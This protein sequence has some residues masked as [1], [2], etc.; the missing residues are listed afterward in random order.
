MLV[1]LKVQNYALI[2]DLYVEF[3]PGLNIITG[4]TGAG[5]S[6]LLGA[7]SL[8]LGKRVETSVLKNNDQ[9]CVVEAEFKIEIDNLKQ[10]FIE[11]DI[12]FDTHVVFRREILNTGKS[13]A[14][15]NDTPVNLNVL[16]E[17]AL[18]LVDIHSQH[19]NLLL[20]Q[21]SYIMEFVDAYAKNENLL[22]EYQTIYNLY[23]TKEKDY[24][25]KLI[26]F[27]RIKDE[28]DL[29]SFQCNQLSEAKLVPG[30]ISELEIEIKQLENAGEIKS[31]LHDSEN[32]LNADESGIIDLLNAASG[33]LDKIKDVFPQASVMSERLI[34]ALIELKDVESE[35]AK[36]FEKLEFNPDRHLQISERLDLLN[37]LLQKFRK[38]EILELIELRDELQKKIS[39][40]VDGEF[41]LLQQKKE[42]DGLLSTLEKKAEELTRKRIDKFP[43][44]ESEISR[45]LIEM[46]MN[47]A[48]VEFKHLL[49]QLSP[50][51][52]DDIGLF[53]TANKN[54]PLQE[55][56]RI[57]SGGELSRLMLAVK[58]L[59]SGS[60]KMPTLILDEIDTGVSGEIA[61]K[62]GNIIKQMSKNSQIINITHLPQV[63]SKGEAHYLVYKDHNHTL[64]RTMIRK[65]NESERV[66][67]IAKMLS[68]EQLSEAAVEN[69]RVLL[70]K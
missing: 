18:Q 24:Q 39:V 10:R 40:V 58:A 9:K 43:A 5:K 67:E 21:Q 56:S 61:D 23:R 36:S 64:T 51:G 8:I 70:G 22:S 29:L 55:V 41:E 28:M 49:Q 45:M 15:I 26:E 52:A 11:N 44:L 20:N 48:R 27:Q 16:Q 31:A 33:R 14:F 65:L 1:S 69:A 19:Q 57:A 54:H 25:N 53:F 7:L 35:I 12:D 68:G 30:E 38:T 13:R 50:S 60:K 17:I 3:H 59:V 62:V 63:A 6:I 37:S 4:E 34:S 32:L 42:L 46:G 66:L 47:H 2:D